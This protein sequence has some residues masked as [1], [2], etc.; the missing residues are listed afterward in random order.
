MAASWGAA[1]RYWYT[2]SSGTP[3]RGMSVTGAGTSFCA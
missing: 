2:S 3:A 1:A